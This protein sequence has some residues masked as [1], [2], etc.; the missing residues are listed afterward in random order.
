MRRALWIL[1][2]LVATYLLVA[3]L[4]LPSLWRHY[5]HQPALEKSSNPRYA[6]TIGFHSGSP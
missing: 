3:Y 6:V 4:I 5:E 2:G 1:V